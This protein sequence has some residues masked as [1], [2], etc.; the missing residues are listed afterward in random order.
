MRTGQYDG[1]ATA[2]ALTLF[3]AAAPAR[4]EET[5]VYFHLDPDVETCSMVIDPSL[6][7]DQWH[8]FV[9][10]VGAI[11]SF[12]AMGPAPTLG[13]WNFS[14][15]IEQG[16]TP[17]DQHDLAWINTFVH[18]DADCPLGDAVSYPLVRAALGVS[19]NVDVGAYW[20]TAVDANYGMVG[21]EVKYA[22]LKETETRP[23][24]ST[25]VSVSLLTGVPDFDVAIYSLD[26]ITSKKFGVLSPYAGF[27]GNLVVGT[28]ETAKVDLHR[29][30]IF[31][32]QGFFGL[33]CSIWKFNLAA[34]YNIATVNTLAFSIGV[35]F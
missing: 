31:V 1:V 19:D 12:K 7:Q 2:L 3:I 6:T 22:F 25:R 27:R 11:S 34:E 35:K 16:R 15:A 32:P 18:P 21:G 17:V 23:A 5:E 20:T 4:G 9:K 14:I 33:A 8:R 10:Q 29:E 13:K 30:N 26:L 28:E 24:A